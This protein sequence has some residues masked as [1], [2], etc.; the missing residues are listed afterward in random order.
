[1]RSGSRSAKSGFS[2]GQK[3]TDRLAEPERGGMLAET[4][5]IRFGGASSPLLYDLTS[6]F[7]FAI[8]KFK[9]M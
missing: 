3:A 4:P 7:F 2:C 9:M 8:D 1:M 5:L 6:D